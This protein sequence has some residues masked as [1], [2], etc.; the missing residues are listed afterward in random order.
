VVRRLPFIVKS[1]VLVYI[2]RG[3]QGQLMVDKGHTHAR[4]VIKQIP[5]VDAKRPELG[6][7]VLTV[8]GLW[9]AMGRAHLRGSWT[10]PPTDAAAISVE[11]TH[12]VAEQ[13]RFDHTGASR[14][15]IHALHR[16]ITSRALRSAYSG[17]AVETA[18]NRLYRRFCA[19][20][21]ELYVSVRDV[22]TYAHA[23]P[24][25]PGRDPVDAQ[26]SH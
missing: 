18:D 16:V 22:A 25:L 11:V 15:L 4:T 5:F 7:E 6:V 19:E 8:S 14:D 2:R 23:A 26:G 21:E 9:T 1:T 12:L 13:E 17:R 20:F 3:G 24:R 10:L